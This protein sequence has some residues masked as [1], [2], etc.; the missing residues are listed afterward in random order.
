MVKSLHQKNATKN[1][2]IFS[3][4]NNAE[5]SWCFLVPF[6]F[7]LSFHHQMHLH[8]VVHVSSFNSR[9]FILI[10]C[11][12]GWM[13]LWRSCT[14]KDAKLLC[15][16]T[17]LK[18]PVYINRILSIS[19]WGLVLLLIVYVY[20]CSVGSYFFQTQI[21]HLVWRSLRQQSQFLHNFNH[22]FTPEKV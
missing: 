9:T 18:T 6:L 13:V 14:E 8:I 12:L 17:T 1:Y 16:E 3:F 15:M 22:K 11:S 4:Q 21:N 20:I 7:L 19:H 2:Y 5:K 10:N